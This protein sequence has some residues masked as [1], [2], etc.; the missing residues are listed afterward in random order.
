MMP[1]ASSADRVIDA[2]VLVLVLEMA[3]LIAYRALR[4]RGMRVGETLAFHGAGLAMLLALRAIAT[5]ASP[6]VFASAMLLSLALHLW[7][8]VQR[9]Q[10]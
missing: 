8:V 2:I 6:L 9:W 7:H 10:R 4:G 5:D 1:F 3:A